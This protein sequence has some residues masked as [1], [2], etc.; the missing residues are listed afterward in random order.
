M[1]GVDAHYA[2]EEKMAKEKEDRDKRVAEI[3]NAKYSTRF[4]DE[5]SLMG[6]PLTVDAATQ[7][8]IDDA[9]D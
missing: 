9:V 4:A 7:K 1:D 6:M 8:K 2:Y 3:N 5:E